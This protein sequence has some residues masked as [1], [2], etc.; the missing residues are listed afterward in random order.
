MI[1]SGQSKIAPL[2]FDSGRDHRLPV[3][4]MDWDEVVGRVAAESLTRP[5]R[6]NLHLFVLCRSDVGSHT[7]DFADVAIVGGRL[8]QV[9]PGQVQAWDRSIELD[10]TLI[11]AGPAVVKPGPWF[12]GDPVAVDLDEVGL[13]NAERLIGALRDEQA[14]F[15]GST[16]SARLLVALFEALSALF[17]RTA[18]PETESRLPPP[19]QDFRRAIEADLGW[20]HDVVDYAKRLGYSAR[21]ID[22]GCRQATGQTA[23]QI[24][25]E[26]LV[27][28][29]KR[30]LA[31]TSDP[32]SSIATTLGFSE[33]T[34]FSKFFAR[35]SGMTPTEFRRR[36]VAASAAGRPQPVGPS[37]PHVRVMPRS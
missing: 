36:R 17:D 33:P 25:S 34:N 5:Q 23:K 12:P 21:T 35:M 8:I 32:A 30:L 7:I 10:A 28:E 2:D 14:R 20:S 22:R 24:L 13:S 4:V 19:Y 15:D 18:S 6:L 37:G 3:E 16:G 29:A 11:L 9:R 31:H 27:L 1:Q 26:R